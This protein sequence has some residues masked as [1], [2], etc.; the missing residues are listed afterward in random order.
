MNKRWNDRRP[1]SLGLVVNYPAL[2]LLRGKA[3]N[4]SPDGMFIETVATSLCN[5]SEIEVTMNLPEFSD[6][7][8]QIQATIIHNNENGIGIMFKD[9]TELKQSDDYNG[10]DIIHQLLNKPGRSYQQAC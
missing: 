7:P 1:V 5:Y 8:V 3:T 10:I 2:G 6:C 4:I 9:N